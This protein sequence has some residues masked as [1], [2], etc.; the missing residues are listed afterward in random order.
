M[1]KTIQYTLIVCAVLSILFACGRTSDN[2][3]LDGMWHLRTL[4]T[5]ETGTLTDVKENRIYYAFQFDLVTLRDI[6][7][8]GLYVGRFQHTSDSLL[9]YDIV[10]MEQEN[11][12]AT[13]EQLLPFGIYGT[14][15]RFAVRELNK[16]KM[17]LRSEEAELTLKKF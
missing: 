7:N 4:E 10:V 16:S 3:D 12:A 6:H 11:V 2:G 8:G 1:K 14:T 13:A 5:L 17:I 15:G 9:I